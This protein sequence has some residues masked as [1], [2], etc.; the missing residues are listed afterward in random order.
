[1]STSKAAAAKTTA[2]G[3]SAPE[4]AEAPKVVALPEEDDEFEDFPV[5]GGR[6]RREEGAQSYTRRLARGV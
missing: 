6:L 4:E 5:E 1:M 3:K 2:D